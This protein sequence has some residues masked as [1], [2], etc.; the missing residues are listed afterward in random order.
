MNVDVIVEHT[1]R[2]LTRQRN[3]GLTHVTAD[4]VFFPDDDSLC[5]PGTIEAMMEIYEVDTEGFVAAVNPA[6]ILE[7]PAGKLDRAAYDMS[8]AHKA[9]AR[10][11]Q[12][13][14]LLA[15]RLTGFNPRYVIG[16]WLVAGAP[17][18]PW[19]SELNAV[20]VEW[21][22]GYRMSFR[23]EVIKAEGFD[24]TFGGYSLF[25]DT[26]A[27]WAVARHGCLIG[28]RK[29]KIYHH[30]FPSGR[31]N[32]YG[33]GAMSIANLAYLMAKHCTDLQLPTA[34]HVEAHRKTKTYLRLRLLSERLR[35]L[36][37]HPGAHDG[38]RGMQAAGPAIDRLFSSPRESLSQTYLTIKDELKID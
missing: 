35:A 12:Y 18:L 6:D 10:T 38:I 32:P 5:H 22:T 34:L 33:L 37:G 29:G 20:H 8:D 3:R 21:L 25:E 19:M 26:D 4:I 14:G 15:R 30:R 36:R 27:S 9:M 28:A 13:R 7:A 11:V 31:S 1:E 16:N 2:G 23:T 17:N 24:E